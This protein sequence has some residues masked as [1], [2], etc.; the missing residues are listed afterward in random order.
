MKKIVILGILLVLLFTLPACGAGEKND[1]T[2]QTVVVATSN[3]YPPYCYLDAN[4]DLTGFEKALLDAV[5]AKL[6]QYK[7]K[8]EVFDFKSILTALD[9]GRADIAAHQ[10]GTSPERAEKYLFTTVP[11]FSAEDFIVV[12]ADESAIATLDDLA[13]KIVSVPPASNWAD[14]VEQYN[15]AHPQNPI[16]IKYYESTPQILSADLQNGVIDAT[17]LTSS[18]VQLMNSMLG[19]QFKTVGQPLSTTETFHVL[20]KDETQLQQAIDGALLE[21]KADGTID[22]LAK[23]ALDSVLAGK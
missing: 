1:G 5:D 10:Y 15:T 22:R 3:D 23:A 7:F 14:L 16:Q 2:V 21:L 12:A 6:P 17:V 13:G 4:G 8:Y 11:Y 20:R 18:D 9:S 19:T